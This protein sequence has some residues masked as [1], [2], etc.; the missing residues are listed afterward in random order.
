MFSIDDSASV[1]QKLTMNGNT[2]VFTK[3]GT[4][5]GV[6]VYTSTAELNLTTPNVTIECSDGVLPES[7]TLNIVNGECGNAEKLSTH[8]CYYCRYLLSQ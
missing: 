3:A 2:F 4:V 8:C 6:T 5:S 1:G 7:L